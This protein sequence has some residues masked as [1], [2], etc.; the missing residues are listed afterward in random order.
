[1]EKKKPTLNVKKARDQVGAMVK[2]LGDAAPAGVSELGVKGKQFTIPAL[3]AQ[4]NVYFGIL[5]AVVKGQ[6]AVA[7]AE[8][9]LVQVE[10]ELVNFV[11]ATRK[12]VKG[13]LGN[14]SPLLPNYGMKADKDPQPLTVEAE[15]AKVAKMKE[16]RAL[17]HTMGSKQK[18]ALKG[19]APEPPAPPPAQPGQAPKQ[20]Q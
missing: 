9:A 15:Q 14:K 7:Q 8:Q 20:G 1:M 6:T 11:Q 4:L 10:P 2:G 12:S 13:A 16:T 19:Q 18:A 17:R 5:D 3:I